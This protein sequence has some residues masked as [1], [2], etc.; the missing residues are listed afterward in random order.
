[1]LNTMLAGGADAPLSFGIFAAWCALRVLSTRNNDPATACRPFSQD[2]DG[3]VLAEG[4]GIV[5]LE[6]LQSALK[7]LRIFT[8]K[9]L[10][11]AQVTMPTTLHN[12]KYT[13]KQRR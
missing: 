12:L 1:M 5:V 13:V 4:A 9:S 8:A 11:M 10:D 3:M 6:E 7:S 2:R